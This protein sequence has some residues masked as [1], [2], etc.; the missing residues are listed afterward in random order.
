MLLA[1]ST[2]PSARRLESDSGRDVPASKLELGGW[3]AG[4]LMTGV[5]TLTPGKKYR[6]GSFQSCNRVQ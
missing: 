2:L 3:G 4:G 5:A 1:L 6:R